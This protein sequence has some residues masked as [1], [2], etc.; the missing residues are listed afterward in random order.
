MKVSTD[1]LLNQAPAKDD[2]YDLTNL[3]ANYSRIQGD[4]P[5]CKSEKSVFIARNTP[6]NW[7]IC[8][9]C[10]RLAALKSTKTSQNKT[11]KGQEALWY[12]YTQARKL[13]LRGIPPQSMLC[14]LGIPSHRAHPALTKFFN[15]FVGYYDA[16][17]LNRILRVYEFFVKE[18]KI[19]PIRKNQ[20]P[21]LLVPIQRTPGIITGFALFAE[22]WTDLWTFPIFNAKT[23]KFY[24]R[25]ATGPEYRYASLEEGCIYGQ[26]SMVGKDTSLAG[27]MLTAAPVLDP[28]A[29]A[30]PGMCG[31]APR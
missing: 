9:R 12:V 13:F 11:D 4:C 15:N 2:I 29:L 25:I 8:V 27:N 24:L 18:K 16:Q 3:E 6:E 20:Y 5:V 30:I 28:S 31:P 14:K 17:T 21:V 26:L 1:P 19:S 23:D 7:T 22:E 10:N